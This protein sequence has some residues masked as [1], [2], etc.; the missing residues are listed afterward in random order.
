MYSEPFDIIFARRRLNFDD[1]ST[2]AYFLEVPP[3]V[4]D[5]LII[6]MGQ[7]HMNH[8]TLARVSGVRLTKQCKPSKI[9]LDKSGSLGG[10]CAFWISG[11]NY[12][13]PTGQTKL[14]PLVPTIANLL[15]HD[16]DIIL[17]DEKLRSLLS[18]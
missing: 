5:S 17:D 14:I 15:A 3:Q 18:A 7:G 6:Y 13:E 9:Y 11:K 1:D 2:R 12:A 10:G 4:G 8:Y 16:R